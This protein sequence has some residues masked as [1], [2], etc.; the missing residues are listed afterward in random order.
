MS[1]A[2]ISWFL[3][4][5]QQTPGK[6]APKMSLGKTGCEKW[7]TEV[8]TFHCATTIVIHRP[9]HE[10]FAARLCL[11]KF[12]DILD[13]GYIIKT[14]SLHLWMISGVFGV[15]GA[16]QELVIFSIP[17]KLRNRSTVPQ[18][19]RWEFSKVKPATASTLR[20]VRVLWA[21]RNALKRC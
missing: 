8:S 16:Q 11:W 6:K 9:C 19:S 20:S 4:L 3:S 1:L 18:P 17:T 2:P 15:V 12:M 14:G 7:G 10:T 13:S 5:Q 21:K